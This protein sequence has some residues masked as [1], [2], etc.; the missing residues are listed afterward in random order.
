LKAGL[1][2]PAPYRQVDL[3]KTSK[4]V[5]RFDSTKLDFVTRELSFAG[6]LDN[7][8]FE[9]WKNCIA[10]DPKAWAE[11]RKYNIQDVRL[12]EPTYEKYLPWIP[13]HPNASLYSDD[14]VDCCTA[15]QS[16]NLKREGFAYLISGKYQRFRCLDCGKWS[17]STRREVGTGLVGVSP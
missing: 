13:N 9:R 2:P 12:L 15:C 7:G 4:K 5:F 14:V 1:E 6:K 10:G 11:M 3:W 17:R 8:G 16:S